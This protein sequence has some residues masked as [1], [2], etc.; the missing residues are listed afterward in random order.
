[1]DLNGAEY[2]MVGIFDLDAIM[3][4]RLVNFGYAEAN[5]VKDNVLFKKGDIVFGHVFHNSK[6]SGIHDDFAYEVHKPHSEEKWSCGYIYKNCLG[7]YVHI[8]LLK[9]PNAVDRFIDHCR[10]YEREMYRYGA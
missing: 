7:T 10:D 2:D 9:Y 1:M 3:T 4:K 8:N 6:M 5:V